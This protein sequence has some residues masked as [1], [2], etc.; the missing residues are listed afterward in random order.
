M[1][2]DHKAPFKTSRSAK[3]SRLKLLCIPAVRQKLRQM[4]KSAAQKKRFA[5]Q[6]AWWSEGEGDGDEPK[7]QV[8]S[9]NRIVTDESKDFIFLWG[10]ELMRQQTA[11]TS[12]VARR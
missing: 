4:G 12:R 7:L 9:S 2:N 11:P 1:K 10:A 8:Q 6:M 3:V 5:G